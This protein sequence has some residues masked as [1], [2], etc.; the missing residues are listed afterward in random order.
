M[1]ELALRE[2]SI[3]E[4]EEDNIMLYLLAKRYPKIEQAIIRQSQNIEQ[5]K[6]EFAKVTDNISEQNKKIDML[7]EKQNFND[8]EYSEEWLTLR[9]IGLMFNPMLNQKQM[10]VLLK[11]LGII[12]KYSNMP[13]AQYYHHTKEPIAKQVPYKRA[14]YSVPDYGYHWNASRIIKLVKSK[15]KAMDLLTEFNTLTPP[16]IWDFING[17]G[18]KPQQQ[19][20]IPQQAQQVHNSNYM[21]Q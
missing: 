19:T 8:I 18:A 7:A 4:A 2:N 16:K 21:F 13:M 17:I 9:E 3:T 12:Q 15:L 6:V 11:N 10:P 1:N 20:R 5:I 14:G